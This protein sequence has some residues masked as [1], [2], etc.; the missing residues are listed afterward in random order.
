MA[1]G[2]RPLMAG[3]MLPPGFGGPMPLNPARPRL[4][5]PTPAAAEAAL[6]HARK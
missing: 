6:P 4:S 1:H 3:Q 5:K 2:L